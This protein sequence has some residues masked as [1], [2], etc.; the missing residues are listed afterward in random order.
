MSAPDCHKN[1]SSNIITPET[2]SLMPVESKVQFLLS[3]RYRRRSL[4]N[5]VEPL[6]PVIAVMKDRGGATMISKRL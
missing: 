6:Q 5:V 1:E 2:V 3:F 4:S